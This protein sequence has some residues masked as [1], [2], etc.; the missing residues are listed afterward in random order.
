MSDKIMNTQYTPLAIANTF[1][2]FDKTTKSPKGIEHLKIQK[3]VYFAYGWWLACYGLNNK[4]LIKEA[5][6]VW[7]Y[8][9]IF[10]SLYA[11]LRNFGRI[12][13][14]ELQT[15]QPFATTDLV[16]KEDANSYKLIKWVWERYGHLNSYTLSDMAHNPNTSWYKT[17]MQ[18]DFLVP[19]NFPIDDKYIYQE[20]EKIL[21][22]EQGHIHIVAPKI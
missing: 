14:T 9:P 6:Q 2:L 21:E 15:I 13:I 11:T 10:S 3:L 5:P 20:F 1:I 17:A 18:H 7:K 12:P 8:G 4:R 16:K 19:Y 22:N